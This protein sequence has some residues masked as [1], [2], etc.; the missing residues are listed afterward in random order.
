MA[1]QI[2]LYDPA[3]ERKRDWFALENVVLGGVLLA[4]AV[5]ALGMAERTPNFRAS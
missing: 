2:N 1:Q 5:G 3:L 4:T